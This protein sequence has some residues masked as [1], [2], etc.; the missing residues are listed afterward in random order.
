MK[1]PVKIL[2]MGLGA[3]LLALLLYARTA[4]F[5]FVNYDD[6]NY[7]YENPHVTQG[8]T[9]ENVRWAFEI[10]GPSMWVPLTWLS[11]QA[12]VECFGTAPAP[13]HLINALLHAANVFLLF[14]LLRCLTG[15]TSAGLVAALLFAAHPIHAE[16]VAWV[17]ERKDVLSGFFWLA[18][19]LFYE[20]HVRRGKGLDYFW[21][22]AGTLLAVM[23]KPLAVTLPCVLFLLDFWPYRRRWSW[24][25]MSEKLPLFGIVGFAAYMTMR[26][27]LSIGAVGSAEVFP[28]AGRI[29]NAAVSYTTYLFRLVWPHNLAVFYPYPENINWP[30]AVACMVFLFSVTVLVLLRARKVPWV[31]V[32]WLWYL[33]VLFPMI[34]IVQAGSQ[35]MADRYLYVPAIGIYLIA[36]MFLRVRF[37]AVFIVLLCFGNVMQVGVWKNSRVLFAHALAVT[38]HNYL[39]ENNLGLTYRDE[40]DHETARGHFEASLAI[41][42]TYAE[43]RN[44]LG[45][46]LADLGEYDAA[47]GHL[48]RVSVEGNVRTDA[49]YNLG[50]ALLDAD[51]PAEAESWF[52]QAVGQDSGN[53]AV[54]YNLGCALQEQRRW[55]EALA[56]F[57][58]TLRLEPGHADAATN[59]HYAQQQFSNAWKHYE[60]GNQ[61]RVQG[62]LKSAGAAYRKAIA[63]RPQFPEA[64]NNLGVVLGTLGDQVAALA[65]FEAALKLAPDYTDAQI[66]AERARVKG[67]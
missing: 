5:D 62:D 41:R 23:A 63:Q 67:M 12:A 1:P 35:A 59:L 60:R 47:I 42:P 28:M 20:R 4:G 37:A 8:L 64:L 27:Q 3:A 19:L 30:L 25:L 58:T 26:C 52:R 7:F 50:T 45:I 16:S 18:T 43:A 39:A 40:H 6:N 57:E 2:L 24:K 55:M 65:C 14:I 48:Q 22:V 31:A 11:H 61:L 51:R 15:R 13:H 21:V 17:T 49:L 53:A 32:G 46:T 44:N 36:A 33:G 56:E 38:E 9:A 54:R 29:G 66:N 10:H 34:G